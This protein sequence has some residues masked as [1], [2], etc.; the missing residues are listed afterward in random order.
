[1]RSWLIVGVVGLFAAAGPGCTH[2]SCCSDSQCWGGYVCSAD[3]A[4]NGGV[5]GSCEM[6]C[7]VD[8][9]CGP[10]GVCRQLQY[11]CACEAAGDGGAG[12]CGLVQPDAG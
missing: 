8:R 3:C 12:N 1:M 7:A 5:S 11:Q 2:N 9:D 10:G 4:V 6:Q